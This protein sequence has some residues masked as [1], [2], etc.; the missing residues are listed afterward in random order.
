MMKKGAGEKK[1]NGASVAWRVFSILIVVGILGVAVLGGKP[2]LTAMVISEGDYNTQVSES[3]TSTIQ[4]EGEARV[5]V[6]IKDESGLK[7]MVLDDTNQI[8]SQLSETNY[9]SEEERIIS[10]N[11]DQEDLNT[12]KNNPAISEIKPVRELGLFLQNASR[13]IEANNTWN[14][15]YTNNLTNTTT[16]ITGEGQTICIIDTGVSFSHNDLQGKN[17]LG[18]TSANI[19]CIN[20]DCVINESLTDDHGHGTFVAGIAVA[21][22]AIRGI[23]PGAKAIGVKVLNS[24][25][26]GYEDDLK[27]GMQWCI[28][29]SA[30][31]NIS[32]ISLSLG[33]STLYTN[34]CDYVDD[35]LNITSTINQAV[36][37]GI[38]VIAA[39]GNSGS[40]TAIASPACIT[41]STAIGATDK[42][43]NILFNRNTRTDLL[44]PGSSINSTTLAGGYSSLSGTSMSTPMVS[45]AFALIGQFYKLQNNSVAGVLLIENSLKNTGKIINDTATSNLYKRINV[46]SA[47]MSLMGVTTNGTDNNSTN[48]TTNTTNQTNVTSY[49]MV[50]LNS[51]IEGYYISGINQIIF[52]CSATTNYTNATL[53][54]TTLKIWNNT[55][56]QIYSDS[57]DLTTSGNASNNASTN[58]TYNTSNLTSGTYYW[59]CVSSDNHNNSAVA[60]NNRTIIKD[61]TSP[62]LTLLGPAAGAENTTSNTIKFT[63]NVTDQ[64]EIAYCNLTKNGAVVASRTNVTAETSYFYQSIY[65]GQYTWSINCTDSSGNTNVSETRTL[66]V[67]YGT[68]PDTGSNTSSGGSSSSSG[69]GGGGSS[70]SSESSSETEEEYKPTTLSI[71]SSDAFTGNNYDV[72]A[73]DEIKFGIIKDGAEK[74]NTLVIEALGQHTARL[75]FLEKE[76]RQT[77]IDG[78]EQSFRIE[79]SDKDDVKI[80]INSIAAGKMNINIKTLIEPPTQETNSQNANEGSSPTTG[81]V[82]NDEEL[83]N[84]NNGWLNGLVVGIKEHSNYAIAIGAIIAILVIYFVVNR[85]VRKKNLDNKPVAIKEKIDPKAKAKLD[86]I[87]DD[88]EKKGKK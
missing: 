30:T 35:D 19:D 83:E 62:M 21:N 73:L 61:T 78:E 12:L 24:Q 16:N 6:K 82:V 63:Y 69:G 58:Y 87:L 59:N 68:N 46:F 79:Y 44:A 84:T 27:L 17:A 11:I 18:N 26:A 75:L 7:A 39:T 2:L 53:I 71:S 13:I 42:N 8:A 80:K 41:N 31:Y 52:S 81:N 64:N 37:A 50:T 10:A 48:Q 55:G 77:M 34:A 88:M 66:I 14:Y 86:R 60:N 65:T 32:V 25:G 22:G 15:Q 40:S 33:T 29:N 36:N 43:D 70:S 67:N 38:A 76:V 47:I 54:S 85:F 28:N 23:A 3:V 72:R 9:V 20:Q 5:I 45:G 51:P 56:T 4:Q 49:V 74:E 57:Y 1:N